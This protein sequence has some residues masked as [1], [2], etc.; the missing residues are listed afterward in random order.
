MGRLQDPREMNQPADQKNLD[1]LI[2]DEF[3]AA[4][5]AIYILIDD[6]GQI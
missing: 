4:L 2:L 3:L 5:G 6:L 1:G